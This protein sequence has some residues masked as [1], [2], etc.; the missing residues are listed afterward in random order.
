M[1]LQT[2]YRP[3]NFDDFYGNDESIDAV[4]S[5]IDRKDFPRA[6]LFTGIAGIGKTTLAWILKNEF[7][8]ADMDYF[9]YNS[10]NTRGID[11]VREIN[12]NAQLAPMNS[13]YKIY[14]L[15]ECHQLT[16]QAQEGLLLLLE[17]PPEQTIFILCT[18]EPN[19][20]KS[21]IKRRCTQCNLSP[22]EPPII[23]KILIEIC[24]KEKFEFPAK[25]IITISK[26][27]NGSPGVAVNMLDTVI[28]LPME[29]EADINAALTVLDR[30]KGHTET[31]V[32]D[33]CRALASQN[34][35]KVSS[36][37]TKFNGE[38]ESLRYAVLGYY[39]KVLLSKNKKAHG[40][41]FKIL[42][43]FSESFIYTK[44]AGLVLASYM[45]C[46]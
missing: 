32:I 45:A 14:V 34:W 21:S 44:K 12:L 19:K 5:V 17:N 9:Y 16:A 38:P 8:C 46:N 1:P 20:L 31:E 40:Q 33:I 39:S 29:N 36:L 35:E 28:D 18:S 42:N 41:A 13:N 22:V 11:T 43:A 3:N 27:C 25:L 23:T 37:L 4:I 26:S 30:M 2:N 7:K 6:Y 15:D 24:K 10:A